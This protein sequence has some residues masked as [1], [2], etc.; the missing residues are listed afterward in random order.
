MRR[1]KGQ[2]DAGLPWK[3]V[4]MLIQSPGMTDGPPQYRHA[5]KL[6]GVA[7]YH[8]EHPADLLDRTFW[9]GVVTMCNEVLG[10]WGAHGDLMEAHYEQA[11]QV[12]FER[13][14]DRA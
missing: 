13:F 7:K 9:R 10:W 8:Q 6:Y 12:L 11:A 14:N 2:I 3:T 4:K 5:R 1:V